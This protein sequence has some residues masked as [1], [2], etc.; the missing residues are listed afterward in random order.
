VTANPGISSRS[1]WIEVLAQEH[2]LAY[3][4]VVIERDEAGRAFNGTTENVARLAIDILPAKPAPA[5]DEGGAAPASSLSTAQAADKVAIELDGAKLEIPAPEAGG[6]VFLE[7]GE[8]GWAAIVPP[9]PGLKGPHR[10]GGFKD[11]FR[12]RFLFVYGTRGGDLEDFRT[13]TKARFDAETFWVRGNAG[14][15]IIPDTAFDAARFKDRSV[16]LYGNADTNG[17]WSKLLAGS[18]V[19]LRNGRARV[20]DKAYTG[21]DI[22]AYFVR[23]RPGSDVASVGVVAWTG[24]AGWLTASPVQYFVS[25]AGFPDLLLLSAETLR[26]G[27]GGIRAI[28]WFGN[29]W[30]VERGD[31]VWN[32]GQPR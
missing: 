14:I 12:H 15:E 2:P 11:A 27:T 1:R 18:P 6:R 16:I 20:G 30:S 13:F 26:S 24:P 22:A 9:S 5:K 17:A 3:S 19:E 21:K 29:D 32:D 10:S 23:P 8:E 28:G 4:K 7:R 31:F 25:G